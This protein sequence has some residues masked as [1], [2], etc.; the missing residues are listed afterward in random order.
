MASWF[1]GET[2]LGFGYDFTDALSGEISSFDIGSE[3]QAGKAIDLDH[4]KVDLFY[5]FGFDL[6]HM[7]GISQSHA[8]GLANRR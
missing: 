2:L 5:D 8:D 1:Y 4:Y 3:D 6:G 7:L